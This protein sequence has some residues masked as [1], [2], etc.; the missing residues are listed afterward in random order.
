MNGLFRNVK[1]NRNL[2]LLEESSDED[3]SFNKCDNYSDNV[4][5]E[6]TIPMECVYIKQFSR[7]RPN[8][9]V[10]VNN[11]NGQKNIIIS[12]ANLKQLKL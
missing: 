3:E 6:K 2:D 12:S 9:V 7:W 11:T 4:D 8:K 1:E 10:N 5:L